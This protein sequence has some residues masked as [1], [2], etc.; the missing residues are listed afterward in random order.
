[1]QKRRKKN[2]RESGLEKAK[3]NEIERWREVKEKVEA[4]GNRMIKGSA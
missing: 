2:E 3:E 4:W 1:M